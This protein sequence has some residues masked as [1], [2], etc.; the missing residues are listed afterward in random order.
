MS[1]RARRIRRKGVS[2]FRAYYRTPAWYRRH[3][4]VRA[5]AQGRCEFCGWR[6]MQQV[7]HRTYARFG[8]EPL[9]DLMAVCISCHRYI[10][11]RGRRPLC[12][13][14]SLLAQGDRGF[15]MSTL[16]QAYLRKS[17]QTIGSQKV[18]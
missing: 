4:E 5:R 11:R 12:A 10:H 3:A 14:K 2:G 1:I 8:Q 18:S 13:A 7:H 15:G 16:W 9:R 17:K 6:P